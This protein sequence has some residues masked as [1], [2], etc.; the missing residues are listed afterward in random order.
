[1][2]SPPLTARIAYP[3]PVGVPVPSLHG[4]GRTS[5]TRPLS[6]APE[7]GWPLLRACRPR[8]W[9]K[10]AIVLV[11]PA[12]AGALRDPGV[13]PAL[14]GACLAFCLMSSATYLVNDVRDREADR[15]HPRKRL[16]PV[17]AGE[18]SVTGALRSAGALSFA[19]VI[20][21]ALVSPLLVL[22]VLAY[23]VLTL[24]YSLLWREVVLMDVIVIATGFVLRAL[25]GAVAIDI[26]LSGSFLVVTSAG[27]LFLIVGKRHGELANAGLQIASRATLSSY[28]P[29]RLRL[30]L[31][32]S[33]GVGC[34]AY[35]GWSLH[36]RGAGPWLALS[37]V[38]FVLW[39]ARYVALLR[40]GAGEA[41]EE[42]VLGDRGLAALSAVWSLLF[43]AGIYG[44]G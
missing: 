2:P 7:R 8:Q 4:E 20:V 27:A 24:S 3:R 9:L 22:V 1:M 16:R 26:A 36:H 31:L 13:L 10:N 32:G 14:L 43:I 25:A 39:L 11:A 19:S 21:A 29:R 5:A 34:V 15:R 23:A 41:P 42:L 17:A 6:R 18:V 37:L 35:A 38:A 30:L 28:T 40:L 33:A 12:S 44:S